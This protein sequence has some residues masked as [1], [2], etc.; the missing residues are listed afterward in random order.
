MSA[1]LELLSGPVIFFLTL[2]LVFAP[3]LW[4][5]MREHDREMKKINEEIRRFGEDSTRKSE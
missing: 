3:G 5:V 1:V 2:L 4:L